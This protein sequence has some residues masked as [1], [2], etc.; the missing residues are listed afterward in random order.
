M[1]LRLRLK[2]D[3]ILDHF[4]G[5]PRPQQVDIL[6]KVEANWDKYDVFV[7][8]A[9]VAV[10]KTRVAQCIAAWN[11]SKNKK[12]TRIITPTNLLVEQ[13]K[14]TFPRMHCLKKQESY[15]CD[16]YPDSM[17]L[18]MAN[19][20]NR[21]QV[22]GEFCPTCAYVKAVRQ[23]YVMPYMVSNYYVYMVHNL[24][25]NT[26]VID[27]AHNLLPFVRNMSGKKLWHH[28]YHF[29][30]YVNSYGSLLKWVN[31]LPATQLEASAKLKLLKEELETGRLRYLVELG[32]DEYRGDVRKCI[33]L[34]PID[35]SKEKPILWP[36]KGKN[37]VEKIVLM[38]ATINEVDVAALGLDQ[39]R[40]LKIT[41]GSAI[42]VEKRPI[43][44]D[45]IINM[46]LAY[47][48]KA[49]PELAKFIEEA[50]AHY[51]G[52][53]GIVH[54]TY[55][56]AV[57]LQQYISNPRILFHDQENKSEIYN[58]WRE[59]DPK[60]GLVLIGA[61]M[62]EGLDLAGPDY[63]WQI[64]SKIP[65]PSLE[66]PAIRYLAENNPKTYAWD[67]LRVLCQSYGRICRT[68]DD[69]G[70]TYILDKQF[71]SLLKRGQEYGITPNWFYEALPDTLQAS[72]EAKD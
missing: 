70:V 23:S 45:P 48:P 68:P 1:V 49:I 64:I 3:G 62:S 28:E 33:K 15:R 56:V 2:K 9:S 19:C 17:E 20:K 67:T 61:G 52:T 13:Y 58:L 31:S 57:K 4:L 27:E 6:N 5:T 43:I 24:H 18:A 26:V 14:E 47:Q 39:K 59:S 21:K 12:K 60:E 38:S 71:E 22:E 11:N 10:G 51:E 7:I 34:L 55:S 8:E 63:T 65:Y 69:Y 37:A 25:V 50:A 46:A 35:V 53:K 44:Y 29:P 66:D 72:L 32:E 42:D 36:N 41:V 30:S 16:C 40:V 54:V